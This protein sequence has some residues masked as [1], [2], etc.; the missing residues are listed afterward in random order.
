MATVAFITLGCKVNQAETESLAGLFRCRG[1]VVTQAEAGADVIVVNTCSVTH[2]GERKSRQMIRRAVR[3]NPDSV[4]VVTGCFAQLSPDEVGAMD[5]VDVVVGTQQRQQ[6][7]DLVEAAAAGKTAVV[8]VRAIDRNALFEDIPAA[9]VEGRTR[10]FLKIQEGCE[11][12]CSY[13][14]IPYARGPLRSRSLESIGREARQLA[15]KGFQEVVLTGINLGAYGREHG[16]PGL[17]AAVRAVLDVPQLQRVRLSSIESLELG[18]ELI[19]LL[20]TE[21][22][23]CPHLHLPLQ[24]GDDSVLAAMHRPYTTSDF[25][26][27]VGKVRRQVP[28]LAVTTD[29]IVGFPGE[30]AAQ[31]EKTLRF[32]ADMEFARIHVFPYS[33]RRGTPAAQMT[34]QV[35]ETEKKQ[36]VQRLL[37]VS[38]VCSTNFRRRFIGSV[39]PVLVE[40]GSG[41]S[42]AGFTPNYL[43]VFLDNASGLA[44]GSSN[45]IVPVVLTGL[46]QDGLDGQV[47]QEPGR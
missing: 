36:R 9:E 20:A 22:R 31:F 25:R 17:A 11:N 32:A 13:C 41:E 1:Y 4:T 29:I 3:G 10:A 39:L 43:R 34:G 35:D 6:I 23:L 8:S 24:S 19:G 28:D 33:K 40:S 5:G 47:K 16:G 14:I 42:S 2:L 12:F 15:E 38:D 18:E 44:F 30:T 21:P 37:D 7:V 45:H 46:H 27:L 26:E